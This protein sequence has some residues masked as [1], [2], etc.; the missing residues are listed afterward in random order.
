M[1]IIAIWNTKGKSCINACNKNWLKEHAK[2][3]P[4]AKREI[5]YI[6]NAPYFF[7]W[8]VLQLRPPAGT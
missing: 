1:H 4:E 2:E 5:N 3:I 6:L 7:F 8:V